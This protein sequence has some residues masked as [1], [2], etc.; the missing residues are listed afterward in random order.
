MPKNNT[1]LHQKLPRKRIQFGLI[2]A[3]SGFLVFLIGG[4][5]ELFQLDRSPVLGF[6]QISVM[7]LGLAI[8]CI[9]GYISISSLWKG[10]KPSIAAELGTRIIGTGFII[11]VFSGLADIFGLGSHPY[12]KHIP[13]FGVWQ[14]RGFQIAEGIIA[15]GILMMLPYAR[16]PLFNGSHTPP[17]DPKKPSK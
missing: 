1:Y 15:I 10:R 3:I 12:P 5:P 16:S 4:K 9:G 13:Y 17:A 8:I 2:T 6:V 11:A 14:A 7:L